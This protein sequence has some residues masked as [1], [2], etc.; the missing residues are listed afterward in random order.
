MAINSIELF[1]GAGGLALGFSGHDVIHK[2]VVEWNAHACN[3]I[4]LNKQESVDPVAHWPDVIEGDVRKFDYSDFNNIDLVTGGPPCQPFSLGGKHGGFLDVR[5]MFP[6]AVRAVRETNPRAFVFEN[7]QGLT[8]TA[9]RD[10]FDYIL[11]QLEFPSLSADGTKEWST[12]LDE[13]RLH[14]TLGAP[15]EY[16]VKWKLVNAANYGVPQKRMRVFI[17]GF[18]ADLGIDFEFPEETHSQHSLLLTQWD[19]G[20]YWRRHRVAKRAQP[21]RPLGIERVLDAIKKN[22]AVNQLAPWLTVR[23]AISDLPDPETDARAS[24]VQAH[25]FQPGARIYPGH[26]GSPL[27]EPAKALKA[28]DHGVP[29]GENMLR[30]PDGTVRYF[31]V[32]ES[33]RIQ[34]FPDNFI[35]QGSWTETMRQLGNA[36]PVRLASVMAERVC[37][38]LKVVDQQTLDLAA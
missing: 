24:L 32:R 11:L 9:F 33:A 10:Y 8:R 36:V 35:F 5:D 27:D 13:L 23:D 17:V 6:Q 37:D 2:A 28:G 12:H 31:T 19:S 3:T 22:Q 1:A 34:T 25:K 26:T 18:R 21:M 38:Y 4:R 20:D 14:K 15:S 29:G 7:V 16:R 30:R